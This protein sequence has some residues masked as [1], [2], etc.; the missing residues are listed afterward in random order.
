MKKLIALFALVSGVAF[1]QN[2][3]GSSNQTPPNP[4][5]GIKPVPSLGCRI[6]QCVNGH[7]E[8]ICDKNPFISCGPQPAEVAGCKIGD[9]ISGKWTQICN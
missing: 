5:C 9:C 8:E 6:G 2:Q 1:A 7:W 4:G 3:T